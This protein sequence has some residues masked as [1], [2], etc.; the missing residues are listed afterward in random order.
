MNLSLL[1]TNP[2]QFLLEVFCVLP[3]VFIALSFHEYAHA[4]VAYK[5]GDNTAKNFGRLSLDPV[6]HIDPLGLLCLIFLGFGWAKPVP[7]NPNNFENRRQGEF[8]VSIAGVTM[9]FILGVLFTVVLALMVKF[10]ITNS[11]AILVIQYIISVNF[12]LMVFNFLPLGPLDGTGIIR[13]ILWRNAYK[14]DAFMQKYGMIILL[15]LLLTGTID[16]FVGTA[17]NFVYSNVVRIIFGL[18]GII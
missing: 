17:V 9:N 1:F 14:F 12:V 13:S 11:T 10:G 2:M 16:T 5:M 7:V 18:F 15:V 4:F 8:L 3:G 6:Q